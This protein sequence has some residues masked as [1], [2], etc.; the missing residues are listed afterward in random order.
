[1][2][3]AGRESTNTVSP[4]RR[5]K[6]FRRRRFWRIGPDRCPLALPVPVPG[7]QVDPC[8]PRGNTLA[9]SGIGDPVF[10]PG[11]QDNV[12]RSVQSLR[13]RAMSGGYLRRGMAPHPSVDPRAAAQVRDRAATRRERTVPRVECLGR[14]RDSRARRPA[15]A[16]DASHQARFLLFSFSRPTSH[17]TLFSEQSMVY[18]GSVGPGATPS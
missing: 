8:G 17:F 7:R 10:A 4:V 1:M 6:S 12:G 11:Q 13:E 16:G 3:P 14:S 15:I 18:E 9:M 2:S 5:S